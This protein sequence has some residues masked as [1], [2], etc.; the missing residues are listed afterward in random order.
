[1]IVYDVLGREINILVNKIQNA[2]N[3]IINFN[4]IDLAS[5]IYFYSLK[6]NDKIMIKKMILL[7]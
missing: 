3:Y 1:M 7:K 2:G 4:A 5:G 6:M